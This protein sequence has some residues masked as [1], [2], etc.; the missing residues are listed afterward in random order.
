MALSKMCFSE[1]LVLTRR[2]L[3]RV[4]GDDALPGMEQGSLMFWADPKEVGFCP[5]KTKLWFKFVDITLVFLEDMHQT[6]AISVGDGFKRDYPID[7]EQHSWIGRQAEDEEEETVSAVEPLYDW[8]RSEYSIK[9]VC[10]RG[11]KG[12]IVNVIHKLH[13]EEY[14]PF[15]DNLS[16]GTYKNLSLI[17]R[18]ASTGHL[19]NVEVLTKMS[20]KSQ[21][22]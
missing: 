7:A 20:F 6:L 5:Q 22:L 17:I 12:D 8:Q 2:G 11:K 15:P 16:N 18:D 1:E 4:K 14:W 21:S 13:E 3:N 19:S 10:P 9:F